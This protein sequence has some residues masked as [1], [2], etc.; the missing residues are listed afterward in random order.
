[1]LRQLLSALPLLVGVPAAS[2]AD[3]VA[4]KAV[5]ARCA[6]CHQVG[7][8]AR[9]AF[10]PQL[11]GVVGRRA[12]SVPDYNYSAA[13]KASGLVWNEATLR[14]FIKAPGDT[15]PGNRMRFWWLGNERQMQDLL[16]Y[17][18]TLK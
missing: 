15:V 1:M 8:S 5:F 2:G 16:A 14:A 4:G 3:A 11:N 13:L 9:S 17:L 10:G 6:A 18:G 7:P 12:G